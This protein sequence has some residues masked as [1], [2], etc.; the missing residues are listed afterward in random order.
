MPKSGEVFPK[1]VVKSKKSYFSIFATFFNLY[2]FVEMFYSLWSS[3]EYD[4]V[5]NSENKQKN[6]TMFFP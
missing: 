1:K 5:L 6:M 3:V 2:L 4:N